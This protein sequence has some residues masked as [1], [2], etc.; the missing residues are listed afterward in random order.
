[1]AASRHVCVDE[2]TQ[3]MVN[4]L[5]RRQE[6]PAATLTVEIG[7]GKYCRALGGGRMQRASNKIV[8]ARF[9]G[10]VKGTRGSE[11]GHSYSR[12]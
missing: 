8:K 4:Q 7:I 2:R 5:H 3:K 10:V 11:Q 9:M 1:M 12:R 6:T